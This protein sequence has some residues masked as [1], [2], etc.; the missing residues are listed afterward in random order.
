MRVPGP[1]SAC[2]GPGVLP[3]VLPVAVT[4]LADCASVSVDDALLDSDVLWSRDVRRPTARAT[5][6][7]YD[8]SPFVKPGMPA[9]PAATSLA[10]PASMAGASSSGGGARS[11]VA[12]GGG[13]RAGHRGGRGR[14]S[15]A[16]IA[17]DKARLDAC[18][19]KF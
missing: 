8:R 17:A 1:C 12:R 15:A 6:A 16:T 14:K 3:G 4:S 13:A 18:G 5:D 7:R 10:T 11:S 2:S 19:L 9:S